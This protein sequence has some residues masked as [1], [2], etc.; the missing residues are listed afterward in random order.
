MPKPLS[1][2]PD[3]LRNYIL[4]NAGKKS[5][6]AMHKEIGVNTLTIIKYAS[7][8]QVSIAMDEKIARQE[9]LKETIRELQYTHTARQ[10]GAMLN[11]PKATVAYRAWV[12]GIK[13]KR[14]DHN[15]E[16]VV[17]T[18]SRFFNPHAMENWLIG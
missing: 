11:V 8:M 14:E 7:E 9:K 18:H 5:V 17:Q 6:H 3:E 15:T 10:I 12:M 13:L 2:A 1:M 4:Q 16:P